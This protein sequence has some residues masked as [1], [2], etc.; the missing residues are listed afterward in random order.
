MIAFDAEEVV[1]SLVFD[2][3]AGGLG[4][5]M[6]GVGGDQSTLQVQRLRQTFEFGDFI[7][8]VRDSDLTS[9]QS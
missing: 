5:S 9:S 7:G 2:Q 6:E 3:V 4:L 1:G 8:F